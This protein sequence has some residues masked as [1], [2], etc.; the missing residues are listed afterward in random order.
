MLRT[1]YRKREIFAGANSHGIACQPFRRNF[2]GFNFRVAARAAPYA[3]YYAITLP[4]PI[5]F[6]AVLIF[7]AAD[8][9]AKNAKFCTM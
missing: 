7:T 4:P 8:L 5:Q 3:L 1:N 6:F 9:S 2:R